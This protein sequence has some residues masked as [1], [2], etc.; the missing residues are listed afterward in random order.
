MGQEDYSHVT[1]N[2][3]FIQQS[4]NTSPM[5]DGECITMSESAVSFFDRTHTVCPADVIENQAFQPVKAVDHDGLIAESLERIGDF[6]QTFGKRELCTV[7][8]TEAILCLNEDRG[9]SVCSEG[10]FS[11]ALLSVD[12]KAGWP[13]VAAGGNVCENRHV[14]FLM[15][16]CW[17]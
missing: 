17:R 12:H 5:A 6:S 8:F 3:E 10:T 7:N 9:R 14:F 1:L 4:K 16:K 11:H 2:P 15:V 13:I